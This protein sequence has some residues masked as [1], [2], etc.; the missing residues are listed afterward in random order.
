MHLPQCI[1]T[2]RY[3]L[4]L[5]PATSLK[6]LIFIQILLI[7]R[8]KDSKRYQ[9]ILKTSK[10]TSKVCRASQCLGNQ[11]PKRLARKRPLK[12]RVIPLSTSNWMIGTR[13]G[14]CLS[15]TTLRPITTTQ[16]INNGCV[17]RRSL[18]TFIPRTT[19]T[20]KFPSTRT[21]LGW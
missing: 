1:I 12:T 19:N 15:V 4:V 9:L 17:T 7:R 8:Q 5:F 18:R 11:R 14:A 10:K 2:R 3:L 6:M 13:C 20:S 16:S 21:P